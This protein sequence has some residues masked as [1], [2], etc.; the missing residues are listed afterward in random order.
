MKKKNH[1]NV[2]IKEPVKRTPY[3][4]IS[5]SDLLKAHNII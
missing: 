3:E 5:N 2:E 1:N 4:T